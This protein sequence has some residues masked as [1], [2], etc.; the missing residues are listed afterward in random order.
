VGLSDPCPPLEVPPGVL[1]KLSVNATHRASWDSKLG[2]QPSGSRRA[3]S[4]DSIYPKGG[5]VPWTDLIV[6][7]RYP[8]QYLEVLEDGQ[9]VILNQKEKDQREEM[10]RRQLES[11]SSKMVRS[12]N[13]E[14]ELQN[15]IDENHQ[16]VVVEKPSLSLSLF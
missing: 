16:T 15:A 11:L 14:Q 10:K 1:L 6:M 4:L 3:S 8:V 2:Y 5:M 13:D 12:M 9:K 7:R